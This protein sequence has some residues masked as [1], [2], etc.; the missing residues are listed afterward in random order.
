MDAVSATIVAGGRAQIRLNK[1]RLVL[2]NYFLLI[3]LNL[4]N[5]FDDGVGKIMQKATRPSNGMD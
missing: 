1:R 4:L 3:L 5:C 2:I